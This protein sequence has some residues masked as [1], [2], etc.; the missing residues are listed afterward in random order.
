MGIYTEHW[1]Q[2]KKRNIRGVLYGMLMLVI[3]LPATALISLGVEELTGEYPAYLHIG[4]LV[5]WLIVL[6]MLIL[7]YS[8]IICPRCSTQ[9]T[10]GKGLAD[11]PKCGL[12]MLQEDP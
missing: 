8:R 6:T 4:L 9:Y 2:Y 12:R 5:I 3:A 1:N 7:R 10:H 11:C